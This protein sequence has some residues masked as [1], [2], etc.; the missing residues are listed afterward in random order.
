MIGDT[1]GLGRIPERPEAQPADQVSVGSQGIRFNAPRKP[2]PTQ[3]LKAA[4]PAEVEGNLKSGQNKAKVNNALIDSINKE[5]VR[6]L[7]I[8]GLIRGFLNQTT[9]FGF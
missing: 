3:P 8:N 4:T 1:S 6:G 2:S 7:K 9:G 5:S